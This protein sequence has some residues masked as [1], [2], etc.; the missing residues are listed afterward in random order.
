MTI[1]HGHD[2]EAS[3]LRGLC[4]AMLVPTLIHTP[5]PISMCCLKSISTVESLL[6]KNGF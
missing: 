1:V 3:A 4:C 2:T 5:T 6:L